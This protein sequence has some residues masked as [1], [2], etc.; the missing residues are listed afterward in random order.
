M[1]VR[2]PLGDILVIP[3]PDQDGA[4]SPNTVVTLTAEPKVSG[5]MET[6]TAGVVL[7]KGGGL[8]WV[9]VDVEQ[10]GSATI[11]MLEDRSVEVQPGSTQ[12][13]PNILCG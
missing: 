9:G 11:Q 10:G 5:V 1:F 4:Y 7:S 8:V 12:P 2:V 6:G 13:H 3:T